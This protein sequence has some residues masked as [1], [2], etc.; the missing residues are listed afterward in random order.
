MKNKLKEYQDEKRDYLKE[1]NL[2]KNKEEFIYI[3]SFDNKIT[4]I[5]EEIEKYKEKIRINLKNPQDLVEFEYFNIPK[6]NLNEFTFGKF[7]F[8][9]LVVKE[10]NKSI[11]I[12][13]GVYIN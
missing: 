12:I 9:L 5:K 13:E 4:K 3:I 6:D 10:K 1:L 8:P 2:L 11:E 7:I